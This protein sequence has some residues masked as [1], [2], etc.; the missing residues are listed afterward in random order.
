[1]QADARADYLAA[2]TP[3]QVQGLAEL[4]AAGLDAL[5]GYLASGA[6]VAFL[7]AGASAP[8]YPMWSE[9]IAELVDATPVAVAGPRLRVGHLPR[10]GQR[11]RAD[12]YVTHALA[13]RRVIS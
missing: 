4:N 1:M 2:L 11:F 5:R 12:L 3:E 6:A 10:L 7:G 8:L 9:L 13:P